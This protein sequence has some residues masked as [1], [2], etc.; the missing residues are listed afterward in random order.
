MGWIVLCEVGGVFCHV[1]CSWFGVSNSAAPSLCWRSRC[2]QL[3][4]F[5]LD[6]WVVLFSR[7]FCGAGL[8]V[9]SGNNVFVLCEVGEIL[10][11]II[12]MQ[13]VWCWQRCYV[14]VGAVRCAQAW[15]FVL[16]WWVIRP[17]VVVCSWFGDE[18][19]ATMCLCSCSCGGCAVRS[20]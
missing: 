14:C 17:C 6:W 8:V 11:C 10:C 20:W 13:M 9:R 18:I 2:A 1:L 15:C 16:D 19:R 12:I 5:V 3:V 4:C 7:V